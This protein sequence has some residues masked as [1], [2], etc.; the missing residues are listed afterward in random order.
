MKLE[1]GDSP[2]LPVTKHTD[3]IW[4]YIGK[5]TDLIDLSTFLSKVKLNLEFH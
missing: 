2:N 1:F 4:S 5:V 3:I